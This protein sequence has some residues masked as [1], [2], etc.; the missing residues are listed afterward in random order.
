MRKVFELSRYEGLK[1]AQIASLL[2]ISVKTVEVHM[3][4]ALLKL[5]KRLVDYTV[6]V[7]ALLILSS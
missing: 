4:R 5:K 3:S 6:V 2:N 1:Y 7:S